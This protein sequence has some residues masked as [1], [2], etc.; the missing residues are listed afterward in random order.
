MTKS[1]PGAAS[2]LRGRAR[3][4]IDGIEAEM[5]RL[6]YWSDAPLPEAAYAFRRAFAQ[7]TMS[8]GQ[9]LQ[10]VLIP[11]VHEIIEQRGEFPRASMVGAQAVR[12]FDGDEHAE[13]L[14]R[15]LNE[16][17]RLIESK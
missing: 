12:E 17:D 1:K 3:A 13:T 5:K 4:A 11:R 14:I 10:F 15:L 8:F 7:D 2:D 9:W 16:F 6:G